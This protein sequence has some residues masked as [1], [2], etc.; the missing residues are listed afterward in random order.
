MLEMAIDAMDIPAIRPFWKAALAYTD[1][2]G[3]DGPETSTAR[4]LIKC[5]YTMMLSRY[6]PVALSNGPPQVISRSSG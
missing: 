6:C 3:H 1:E 2:P 4:Q 5:E